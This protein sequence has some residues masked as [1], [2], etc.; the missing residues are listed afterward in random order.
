M[1]VAFIFAAKR[2]K[3][4]TKSWCCEVKLLGEKQMGLSPRCSSVVVAAK[5]NHRRH[6]D[7]AGAFGIVQVVLGKFEEW[8]S[9]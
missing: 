8:V 6:A 9:G 7:G 2:S 5:L 4:T 1:G 3:V